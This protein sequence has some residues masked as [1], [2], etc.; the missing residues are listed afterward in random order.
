MN[1][2]F[3]REYIKANF[4]VRLFVGL[5]VSFIKLELSLFLL[6][7][8]SLKI[9]CSAMGLGLLVTELQVKRYLASF[10]LITQI[11][12]ASWRWRWRKIMQQCLQI[13]SQHFQWKV[14]GKYKYK[15]CLKTTTTHTVLHKSLYLSEL[16]L[17]RNML[18]NHMVERG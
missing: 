11:S 4:N 1:S 2:L 18:E 3:F 7:S 17:Q 6:H 10:L 13:N 5:L 15:S 14:W 8:D 9:I 16:Q 12:P